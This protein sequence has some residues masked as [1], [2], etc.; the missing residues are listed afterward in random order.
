MGYRGKL[1]ECEAARVLRAE[2]WTL[3]DIAEKLGVSKSSV[4]LWVRDVEFQPHPRRAARRRG[5]NVL[6][7]RKATEIEHLRAEGILRLG[8][9][10]DQAFLAA[11][12][13]LYAGEGSKSDG[14]ICF[15]NCDPKM[16]SFFC[17]WFRHFF[18]I[19]ET[20]LTVRVYLHQGLDLEAAQSFWSE[21]TQIPRSQFRKGYRARADE[22]IRHNKHEHGCAYVRYQSTRIHREIMGLIAALLSSQEP[23][24]G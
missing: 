17:M 23:G 11:G 14:D 13:A 10:S 9:L 2:S 6:Q 5:P 21:V 24:P 12:A 7:R 8:E 3:A 1:A 22:S 15:A 20:R 4:S 19:D 16:I 18:Q